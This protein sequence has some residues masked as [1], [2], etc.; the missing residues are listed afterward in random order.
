VF[1]HLHIN[2]Y[3]AF[4]L[5]VLTFPASANLGDQ[6]FA[7]AGGSGSLLLPRAQD[8]AITRATEEGTGE[9]VFLG[10]DFDDR[11]SGQFQLYSLGEMTFS[12]NSIATYQAADASLLYRFFD[13]RDYQLN[14]V[15]GTSIYGRFGLGYIN[16][17][18]EIPLR[19]NDGASVYFGVGGGIEI[20]LSKSLAIRAEAMY[21]DRDATTASVSLVLRTGGRRRIPER[22]QPTT[23]RARA[24]EPTRSIVE[25]PISNI[26]ESVRSNGV[27][28]PE[29]RPINAGSIQNKSP[30]TQ[31]F[32]DD[33]QIARAPGNQY[34]FRRN[35]R[36]TLPEV[37]ILGSNQEQR[38]TRV[39][40]R[41][42]RSVPVTVVPNI[43]AL[44]SDPVEPTDL[45][46][47]EFQTP[48]ESELQSS[49]DSDNDGIPDSADQCNNSTGD[50]PVGNNGCS[51][52]GAL[53]DQIQFQENSPLP[54]ASAENALEQLAAILTEYP[55]KSIELSAHTDN[56]G[57]AQDRTLL[58]RQRLRAIGI[59][60]VQ[61]GI[62]KDRLLLRS[63][64]GKRPAFDNSTAT[65]RQA[66]NRIE[67]VERP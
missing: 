56:A 30:I 26:E 3:S 33:S 64:G 29:A 42:I 58:T 17:D 23:P 66:N 37:T 47:S 61:R 53:D 14:A 44:V 25:T 46:E 41:P 51:L 67:I 8:T 21:L 5:A 38:N 12:D 49:A 55:D 7:G 28:R 65:G 32:P 57:S 2:L 24:V 9:T 4:V 11:S 34:D 27:K 60:L 36:E 20:Y 62:H 59:Y 48:T 18:S 43:E 40:S 39:A 63:F 45:V 22:P 19:E 54:L 10:R 50:L 6:W 1:K 16:R 13:S 31:A 15:F 35:N 52:I